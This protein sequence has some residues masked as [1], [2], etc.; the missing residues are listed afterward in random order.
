MPSWGGLNGT[1]TVVIDPD[2]HNPIVRVTDASLDRHRTMCTGLGGSGDMPQLWNADS[3]ILVVCDNEGRYYPIGF[4]PINFKTTGPLYGTSPDIFASGPGVFSHTDPNQYYVFEKGMVLGVNYSNRSVMPTPQ[5]IYDFHNCGMSDFRWQSI[6]GSDL[7]DTIFSV[8]FSSVGG[9]G[10]GDAIVVYNTAENVCFNLNTAS[11]KVTRYP[12]GTVVG[13]V[14]IPDRF[15]I[16]NMKMKGGTALVVMPQRCV[17]NC[18]KG[19]YAWVIGTTQMYVL[20]TPKGSGHWAA[21]CSHWLNQP[22]DLHLYSVSRPY[23]SPTDWSPVWSVSSCGADTDMSCT[24]PFD[25]HPAWLGDCSDTGM[26]LMAT[27]ARHDIID[28]PYQNEIVGETTDGS[29]RQIRFAHTYSSLAMR[30]FDA[31]WSIGQPS[32]DGRFYAWTTKAGGQFGC[33]NG[34]MKCRLEERRSDVL[35]VKLQ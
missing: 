31:E 8:A 13:T 24:Q 6:G 2:F 11:G 29:N 18:G 4:D 20:G 23:E 32:Q 12:G 3:T 28:H 1:N 25:S 15:L 9:Q 10:T 7:T 21:G 35:V 16:H 33:P 27:A 26:V 30:G 14:N 5:V 34:R 22:G 17:A 19:P